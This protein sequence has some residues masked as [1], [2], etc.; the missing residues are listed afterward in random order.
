M[1]YK[2]KEKPAR[3]VNKFYFFALVFQT[4]SNVIP[5]PVLLV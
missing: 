2:N 3:F 4:L 1:G 5:L